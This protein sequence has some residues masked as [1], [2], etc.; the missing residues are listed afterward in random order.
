MDISA[1]PAIIFKTTFE[2]ATVI[3]QNESFRYFGAITAVKIEIPI[4]EKVYKK[5]I[6]PVIG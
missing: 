3:F 2:L 6:I 1:P 5:K 4:M